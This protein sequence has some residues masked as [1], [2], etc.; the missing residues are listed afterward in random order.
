MRLDTGAGRSVVMGF[1]L[2][3]SWMDGK[4]RGFLVGTGREWFLGLARAGRVDFEG[5]LDGAGGLDVDGSAGMNGIMGQS[6]GRGGDQRDEKCGGCTGD[7]GEL[8]DDGCFSRNFW[9]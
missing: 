8:H 2:A 4:F 6:D 5:V 3:T 7:L 1:S 9:G